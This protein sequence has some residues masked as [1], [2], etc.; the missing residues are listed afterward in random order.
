[1]GLS[2]NQCFGLLI[3]S[4]TPHCCCCRQNTKPPPIPTAATPDV[5]CRRPHRFLQR[6]FA[7]LHLVRIPVVAHAVAGEIC[8]AVAA[9]AVVGD[10]RRRAL[11][12]ER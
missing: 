11:T 4:R 10:S 1:M 9:L 7:P 8:V 6:L 2:P 5:P 12:A 3:Y